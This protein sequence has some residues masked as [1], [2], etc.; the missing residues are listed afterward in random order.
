MGIIW[1]RKRGYHGNEKNNEEWRNGSW[2]WAEYSD[3]NDNKNEFH[4]FIFD[5]FLFKIGFQAIYFDHVLS[6]NSPTFL[7]IQL[8][9]LSLFLCVSFSLL[10]PSLSLK[11]K[12]S[13]I[14]HKTKSA[15][16][17]VTLYICPLKLG[18]IVKLSVYKLDDSEMESYVLSGS[19]TA[20]RGNWLKAEICEVPVAH[21]LIMV[22]RPYSSQATCNSKPFPLIISNSIICAMF[23][24]M[25]HGP[26]LSFKPVALNDFQPVGCDPI[27]GRRSDTLHI[28]YLHCNL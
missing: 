2:K 23:A 8:Y 21:I 18:T 26:L 5:T 22:K 12:S 28:R 3:N 16:S 13:K 4:L 20:S 15:Q 9:V 1:R 7:P 6:L 10:P 14:K 11:R 27:G 19:L 17:H 24:Q 25:F